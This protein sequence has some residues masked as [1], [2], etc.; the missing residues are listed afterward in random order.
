MWCCCPD[1]GDECDPA[2]DVRRL[3]GFG[4]EYELTWTLFAV[5]VGRQSGVDRVL[6]PVATRAPMV[7]D[8]D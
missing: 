1:A 8:L 6:W 7:P 4:T 3:K 2:G 5:V